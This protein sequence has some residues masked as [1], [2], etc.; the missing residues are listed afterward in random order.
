MVN[1]KYDFD[2]ELELEAE[3]LVRAGGVEQA[4]SNS[5]EHLD[6][7]SAGHKTPEM[8]C[9]GVQRMNQ[10]RVSTGVVAET[11]ETGMRRPGRNG[12][13]ICES[14]LED[15]RVVLDPVTSTVITVISG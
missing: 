3:R 7:Q 1:M 14:F 11:V 12:M 10:R 8:T 13:V 15:V 4:L 5:L 6:Y 9:H 2:S